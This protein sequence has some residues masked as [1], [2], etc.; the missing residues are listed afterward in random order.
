MIRKGV[1]RLSEKIMLKQRAKARWRFNLIS[2]RFSLFRQRNE[3]V[4]LRDGCEFAGFPVLLG[5]FD[6]L[7][8]GGDEVP[9]DVARGLQRIAAEKHHA[10]GQKRLHGDGVA[11]AE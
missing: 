1:Q 10:R 5:L 4:F 7:L 9:P 3:L 8:A 11:R 2:S 6:T